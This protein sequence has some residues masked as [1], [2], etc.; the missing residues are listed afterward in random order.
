MNQEK[1]KELEKT[2][3]IDYQN[4]TGLVIQKNGVKLYENYFN[5]YDAT[6]AVH[7]YSVTK[8]IISALIGIAIDQDKCCRIDIQCI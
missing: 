8:S 2:I 1:I 7:V 6:N 3:N 5:G 4:I